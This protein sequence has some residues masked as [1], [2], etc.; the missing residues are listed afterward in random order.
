MAKILL[1]EPYKI[2]RQAIALA[3]FPEHDVQAEG[4]IA[5]VGV[6]SIKDC[7][8]LIVDG[9]ALKEG[10]QL[11][12][13]FNRVIQGTKVPTIWL[14]GADSTQPPRLAKRE[15]LLILKKPIEGSSFQSALESLLSSD[16]SPKVR[17]SSQAS[18]SDQAKQPERTAKKGRE[19]TTRKE[20]LGFIDLI[21]VVEELPQSKQGKK[22]PGKRK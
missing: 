19:E 3:L 9:E 13:E 18:L 21:D 1:I 14:E 12:S 4:D 5:K 7:D 22:A 6:G 8:L 15:K 10:N 11:T 2:L 17:S 16:S 20:S